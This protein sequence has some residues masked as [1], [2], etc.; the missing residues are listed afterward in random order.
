MGI[1]NKVVTMRVLFVFA[2]AVLVASLHA[3][4]PEDEYD[5]EDLG[6]A[7][8]EN[9]GIVNKV[10]DIMNNDIGEDSGITPNNVV[11]HDLNTAECL[12]MSAAKAEKYCFNRTEDQCEGKMKDWFCDFDKKLSNGVLDTE[13]CD[14]SR[15][16]S[17]RKI[18]VKEPDEI[19][20]A[21]CC[22]W[23]SAKSNCTWES[24]HT[25]TA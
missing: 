2:A 16:H 7:S 12:Q 18:K 4:A 6:A 25:C 23:D 22:K 20:A 21:M 14:K 24:G 15:K 5:L 8:G 10:E 17:C 1:K 3:E 19:Y 11:T 13:W 9:L